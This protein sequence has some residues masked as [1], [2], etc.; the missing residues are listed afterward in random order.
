MPT[1]TRARTCSQ[2]DRP[3]NPRTCGGGGP[4]RARQAWALVELVAVLAVIA[5]LVMVGATAGLAYVDQLARNRERDTL[6]EFASALRQSIMRDLLIPD[7]TGYADQIATFSGR[8]PTEVLV[9]PRGNPRLLLIDPAVTNSGLNLPFDQMGTPLAGAGA[10]DLGNFRMMLVSSL[11]RPLPGG[12]V[13]L[14]PGG[15]PNAVVFSNF[16][17]TPEGAVP[18]GFAVGWDPQDFFIQRIQLLDLFHPV[19]LNHAEVTGAFT[20]GQIRLPGMNAFAPPTG[21]PL[22]DTRWYLQGTTLVLSNETDASLLSEIVKEPLTFTYEKGRW[23]RGTDGLK[24][25]TDLRSGITGA[26]FEAAVSEFL[27]SAVP[28]DE[29]EDHG[30]KDKGSTPGGMGNYASAAQAVNAMSNYIRLGAL[31]P[32]QKPNMDDQLRDLRDA[33]LD[34]T[35]LPA[36]QLNKP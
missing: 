33:L 26:D 31:G 7:Q 28:P 23:V 11:G 35:T 32:Q 15:R 19:A 16:W 4:G 2:T 10:G 13:P 27:A 8:S 17:A 36:G 30:E 21:A 29:A 3:A 9:N 25:A 22:P 20:N 24:T 14:P 5:I 12:L 34:Y 1:T 6:T 18:R